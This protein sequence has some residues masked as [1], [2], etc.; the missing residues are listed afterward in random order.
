MR[1]FKVS[2]V[3]SVYNGERYLREAIDSILGQTFRDFEFIIVDDGSTDG[4]WAILQS[5]DDP[6]IFLLRNEENIGL[7]R[8]L[9]KGLAVVQGD[10]I[11]RMDA[12]DISW[13]E[14]LEKQVAYLDVHPEVG[15]IGTSVEIIGERGERLAVL[16]RPMDPTF[17][18]WSLL[19]DNCLVHSTVMY[20]RSLVEKLGGYNPSRYAQDYGLWSRMSFE[21]QVAKLP[22][23]LV[24]WRRHPAG[25]TAQKLAR[26]EAFAFEISARNI[27]RLLSNENISTQTIEDMRALW[28]GRKEP[29]RGQSL[30][31]LATDFKQL[32]SLFCERYLS[33]DVVSDVDRQSL[34]KELGKLKRHVLSR[35]Y[36]HLAV[37]YYRS[38]DMPNTR[39]C[40][41]QAFVLRPESVA[42]AVAGR[43]VLRTLVGEK[44]FSLLKHTKQAFLGENQP[45]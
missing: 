21:T 17:I 36:F 38:G 22:E 14:R 29:I 15:L 35:V 6:R 26:Q 2:V 30:E 10:Y 13:P 34:I 37:Q 11:A 31:Q 12:D 16:R 3:M 40:L 25:I 28:L 5:Y 42:T 23:V 41:L 20:R 32:L 18:T 39:R 8:S 9:N 24:S 44:A 33:S 43:V 1:K 45:G 4:T 27:R 19:F 7:T